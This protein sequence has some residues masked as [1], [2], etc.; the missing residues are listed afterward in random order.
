M[1]G[2]LVKLFDTRHADSALSFLAALTHESSY[3][4]RER[5]LNEVYARLSQAPPSVHL[6]N[7]LQNMIANVQEKNVLRGEHQL[8]H[9]V[10]SL[11]MQFFYRRERNGV[12][13]KDVRGIPFAAFV[14]RCPADV[15]RRLAVPDLAL[16]VA[17]MAVES[18]AIRSDDN[19]SQAIVCGLYDVARSLTDVEL[20]EI[21]KSF[22]EAVKEGLGDQ[23][24]IDD[25][26]AQAG[27]EHLQMAVRDEGREEI[28]LPSWRL[29]A[30]A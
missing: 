8:M 7:F 5:L 13:S 12:E 9:R 11:V 28:L 23:I 15:C 24:Y 29:I 2:H 14:R 25:V 1:I 10:T 20:S 26:W 4:L 22:G 17:S 27:L 19:L 6:A 16:C 30:Q 21:R 18:R 3:R